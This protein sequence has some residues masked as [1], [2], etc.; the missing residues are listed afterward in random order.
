MGATRS[1]I[2]AKGIDDVPNPLDLG[3]IKRYFIEYILP[4]KVGERPQYIIYDDDC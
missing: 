3:Q 1:R 2:S 4:V